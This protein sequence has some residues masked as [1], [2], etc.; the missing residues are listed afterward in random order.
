M[1]LKILC[2]SKSLYS[3]KS[4][5]LIIK[6]HN[7]PRHTCTKKWRNQ[8]PRKRVCVYVGV[9]VGAAAPPPHFSSNSIFF[10]LSCV[11]RVECKC[12]Y[13]PRTYVA[14]AHA[15]KLLAVKADLQLLT[16]VAWNGSFRATFYTYT[17]SCFISIPGNYLA[18]KQALLL[19]FSRQKFI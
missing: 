7:I 8:G 2:S 18:S 3:S 12:T 10:A 14:C 5:E 1:I 11:T 16:F 6:S 15:D 4:K 9:G 19:I 13:V 17:S